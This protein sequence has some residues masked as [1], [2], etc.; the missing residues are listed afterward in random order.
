MASSI[1]APSSRDHTTITITGETYTRHRTHW[2]TDGNLVILV[3]KVAFRVF[4]SFLT[5]RS[6]VMESLIAVQQAEDLVRRGPP[7]RSQETALA[8]ASVL[9]LV[10]GAEDVALLLDVVLPQ[11]CATAPISSRTEWFRLLGLAQIAHKY[12]VA[13]VLSQVL[14]IL[15]DVLPTAQ[16]P[17]RVRSPAEAAI[18]IYW[19]RKCRFH[20]FLPLA[21]YYLVT[22]EWQFNAVNSRALELFSTRDRLR[23]QQGQARLQA[24]VIKLAMSRWENCLI[25]SSK[26]KQTCPDGRFTCWM[27]YGGKLWP[28]AENEARW[29]NLLLHPLEE[30]RMRSDREVGTLHYL[31]DSCRD[32]FT[33]VN[34]LMIRDIVEQLGTF[35]T[36]EDESSP[37]GVGL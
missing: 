9:R 7:T 18:I 10:D 28:T 12:A 13:D 31:C 32:R 6:A 21:F 36:L 4:Q 1:P 16:H 27:G 8:G 19:A 15:E 34:G 24:R 37:F 23:A 22:G 14:A 17:H 33:F 20:Q 25:G 26:P 35:F 5:R 2:Y 11:S 3:E 30:L 29:T